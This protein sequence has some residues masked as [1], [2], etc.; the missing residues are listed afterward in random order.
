MPRV[1]FGSAAHHQHAQQIAQAL[2]EEGF[3]GLYRSLG[4]DNYQSKLARGVRSV[5]ENQWPSLDRRL[6]NRRI[7]SVPSSKVQSDWS[8][9][10]ARVLAARL[11]FTNL[12]DWLWERSEWKLDQ[13]LASLIQDPSY[14]ALFGVEH[15]C[16]KALQVADKLGKAKIVAFTSPHHSA[17]TE[18]VYSEYERFPSLMSPARKAI[19]EREKHRYERKDKEA[20]LATFI[21]TNSEFS[22]QTLISGGHDPDKIY[23][24]PLGCPPIQ[25]SSNL[26]KIEERRKVIFAGN[27]NVQKGAHYLIEAWKMIDAKNNFELHLYGKIK[28]PKH[29]VK[30]SSKS[31][32]FHGS[33]SQKELFD[34]FCEGV[35]LVLPTL[36]DGFGMVV[37]EALA[38]GLPVITT[39]NAGAADLI[40]EG[41]NGFIVDP[42]DTSGLADRLDWCCRNPGK[43]ADMRKEAL[44]TAQNWQWSDFRNQLKEQ[45]IDHIE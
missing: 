10:F 43:L 21:H 8:L 7:T 42:R 31:T 36:L 15:G 26:E 27:V 12:A 6:E 34:A 16:L 24:A 4:V 17:L 32:T 1:L 3:L 39:C 38:H 11:N 19:I 23:A 37:T 20:S 2:H 5:I 9:E 18:W 28:L 30:K 22:R 44:R 25:Y 35:V 29:V 41:R 33:V 13:D 45:I 40:D 14:D